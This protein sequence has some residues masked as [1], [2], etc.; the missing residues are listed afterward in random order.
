MANKDYL[1]QYSPYRLEEQQSVPFDGRFLM[2]GKLVDMPNP[3]MPLIDAVYTRRTSRAYAAE[4]VDREVFQWLV[5]VAMNAPTACNEQQWKIVHIQDPETIRDLYERGSAAFLKNARQCFLICYNSKNDNPHWHDYVQSGSAFAAMFQLMAHSVGIGSCWICHLPN[6]SELKRMFNIHKSYE[7][8]CLVSYGY[9]RGKAM[10]TPRKHDA[11]RI[12][13]DEKFDS[14]NLAF[15]SHRKRWVRMVMRYV[16]YKI[17]AIFRRR[18][19][20]MSL[21]YEKKFY[22]ETHD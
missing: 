8:V 9:Y 21:P 15:A 6:K 17:P 1:R 13:M 5:S 14:S 3:R 20:N 2:P 19:R 7:P 11:S 10:I 16:Y 4:P 12:I 22:H 18:L